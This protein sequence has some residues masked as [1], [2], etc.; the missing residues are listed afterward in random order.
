MICSTAWDT[1]TFRRDAAAALGRLAGVMLEEG[2]R[3]LAGS[4]IELRVGLA[5][6]PAYAAVIGRRCIYIYVCIYICIYAIP[7]PPAPARL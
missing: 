4:G 7:P 6:G 5:S 3:I 2:R 1:R